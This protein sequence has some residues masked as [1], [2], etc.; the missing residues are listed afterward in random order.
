MTPGSGHHGAADEEIIRRVQQGDAK[1]FSVIFERYYVRL[2]RF[3]RQLGLGD[4]D[5]EDALGETFARAFSRVQSFNPDAGAR[6]ASYLYAIARNLVTDRLRERGRMPEIT[7]LEDIWQEADPRAEAPE[8]AVVRKEQVGRI[9]LALERLSASD[10]EIISLSYD[11]ELS[12]R[13]I[14]QVMGKPSITSVTTH[15]YKAMKRLRELV[16]AADTPAVV[17]EASG[18]RRIGTCSGAE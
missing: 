18:G 10:R 12:C 14:M 11:R 16:R 8:D 1:L 13:E 4:A 15:L 3:I 6:Y 2:E 17:G 5:L 7:L 9:R